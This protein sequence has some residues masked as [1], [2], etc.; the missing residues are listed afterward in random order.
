MCVCVCKFDEL[1]RNVQFGK[2]R[3]IKLELNSENEGSNAGAV[4]ELPLAPLKEG[5]EVAL[6]SYRLGCCDAFGLP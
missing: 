4:A 5:M 1:N 6:T 3:V 2:Y